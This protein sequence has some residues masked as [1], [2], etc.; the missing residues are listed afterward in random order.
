MA[1]Q[2]EHTASERHTLHDLRHVTQLHTDLLLMQLQ[3]V[4]DDEELGERVMMFQ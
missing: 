1:C 4:E 2:M 3:D